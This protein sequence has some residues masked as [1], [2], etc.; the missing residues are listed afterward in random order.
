[1]EKK[2]TGNTPR[3]RPSAR[4]QED[5]IKNTTA[6]KSKV[7]ILNGLIIAMMGIA[8]VFYGAPIWGVIFFAAAAVLIG[9]GIRYRIIAKKEEE[10][11]G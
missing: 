4:M 2:K 5:P 7:N 6:S 8:L 10:K 1:M 3:R 11:K 9:I